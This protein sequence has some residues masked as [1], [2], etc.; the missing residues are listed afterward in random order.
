MTAAEPVPSPQA[1]APANAAADGPAEVPPA[2]RGPAA[3]RRRRRVEGG[4]RAMLNVRYT[5]EELATVTARAAA[6][7]W[8]VT[9][10]VAEVALH[11]PVRT[12]SAPGRGEFAFRM[13]APERSAWATELMAVRRIVGATANNINQLARVANATGEVPLETGR[14]VMTSTRPP[15]PSTPAPPER[16]SGA[17]HGAHP[18]SEGDQRRA[19]EATQDR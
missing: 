14:A 10:F 1:D 2:P 13:S 18:G 12:E 7:G 15:R 11:G 9:S 19:P 17:E 8:E 3:G 4:R 16:A 6:A 5:D